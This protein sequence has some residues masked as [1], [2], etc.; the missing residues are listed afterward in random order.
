[1]I[2]GSFK[3]YHIFMWYQSC[4]TMVLQVILNFKWSSSEEC[5]PHPQELKI[6]EWPMLGHRRWSPTTISIK[7]TRSYTWCLKSYT[8]DVHK[9]CKIEALTIY[10]NASLCINEKHTFYGNWWQRRRDC[11]KIWKLWERLRQRS[12]V[13]TWTKREQHW[14]IEKDQNSWTREAHK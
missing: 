2:E 4:K 11:T 8:S 3:W 7:V 6:S 5:F 12:R 1:M 13:W 14:G 10:P 9:K